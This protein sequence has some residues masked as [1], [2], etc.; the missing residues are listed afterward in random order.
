MQ[1]EI[2]QIKKQI[3]VYQKRVENTPKREEELLSIQRD[4]DN[5]QNQYESL[6]D[7]QLEA[8]LSVNMEKKQQ[9]EQF[10]IIDYARVPQKP[11]SPDMQK[12]LLMTIAAGL[13]LGGGI[14]FLLEFMNKSF[15]S[16][17]KVESTLGLPVLAS[18]PAILHDKD[19]AKIK[20]NNIFSVAAVIFSGL[21]FSGFAVIALKG[22][23]STIEFIKGFL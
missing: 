22:T 11:V 18:V 3:E 19:R 23:D 5:L 14:I 9:G 1:I 4:Y 21:L 12:L 2:T 6:R 17:E 15:K 13:G 7:R 20:L 8:E 16:I 10:Q